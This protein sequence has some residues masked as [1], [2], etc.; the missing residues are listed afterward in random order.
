MCLTLIE[1]SGLLLIILIG[2]VTLGGGTGDPGRAFTFK[3]GA[4][5]PFAILGG[6]VVAF[7]AFLGFEN[8]ANVA[9]ET[10]DP[11]G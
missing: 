10:K 7:Y 6:A 9:E 11:I 2:A 5:V 3:E 1:V 8:A 4:N